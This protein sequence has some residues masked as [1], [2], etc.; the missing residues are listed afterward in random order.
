LP[1]QFLA[2]AVLVGGLAWFVHVENRHRE[3]VYAP[4]LASCL[5]LMERP[6]Q[7]TGENP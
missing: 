5:R 6:P 2:L 1:G 4:L 3:G 7:P